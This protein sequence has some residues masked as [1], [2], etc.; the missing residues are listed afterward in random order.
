MHDLRRTG[1]TLMGELGVPRE[2]IELCLNH[3]M[4]QRDEGSSA[5]IYTYQKQQ[6]VPER[7]LAFDALGSYL[8]NLLG[9]PKT[10]RQRSALEA[11]ADVSVISPQ[12]QSDWT[13]TSQHLAKLL[14]LM[15]SAGMD[16]ILEVLKADEEAA[17]A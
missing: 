2:I 5:L 14:P 4:P 17:T 8:V 13:A 12:Y 15:Q 6:R 16:K 3:R 9:H 10:W 1:A 11:P 7:R